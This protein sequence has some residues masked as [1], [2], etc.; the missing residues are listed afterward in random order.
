MTGY[1]RLWSVTDVADYLGV[2]VKT[3]YDWRTRNYGPK[4]RRVGR[5]LRYK[6]SEVVGWF[7][8]LPVDVD[9]RQG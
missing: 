4:A 1:E 5:H 7:E 2:P 6:R 3:L 8:S 9:W